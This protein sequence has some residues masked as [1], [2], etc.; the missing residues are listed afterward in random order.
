MRIDVYTDGS[1][2]HDPRGPACIG[3]H[4]LFDDV[5]VVEASEY[6]GAGTNQ[7]AELRAIRRGLHLAELVAVQA[8]KAACKEDP[9][10]EDFNW[11][12]CADI[13]V[14]SDSDAALGVLFWHRDEWNVRAHA[15]L[16]AAIVEQIATSF[17]KGEYVPGHQGVDG[18]EIADYLAHLARCRF[19]KKPPEKKHPSER[20]KRK[21]SA[22]TEEKVP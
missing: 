17:A 6:V 20:R 22:G 19:L 5:P 14:H 8:Y 18:N 12:D 21:K 10:T 2:T 1:G 7:L 16:I 3:V 9:E 4:V 15:K 11:Q 13:I